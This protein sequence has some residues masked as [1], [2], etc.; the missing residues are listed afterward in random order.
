MCVIFISS[1]LSVISINYF[2]STTLKFL[3]L[4]IVKYVRLVNADY[5]LHC[6]HQ[7]RCVFVLKVTVKDVLAFLI[8]WYS[9]KVNALILI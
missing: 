9:R 8:C 7:S 5:W 6:I 3:I 4:S 1:I 2:I